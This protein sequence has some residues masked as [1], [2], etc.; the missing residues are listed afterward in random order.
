MDSQA[1]NGGGLRFRAITYNPYN[2]GSPCVDIWGNN[3]QQPMPTAGQTI[4]YVNDIFLW[5]SLSPSM[6]FQAGTGAGLVQPILYTLPPTTN[7]G[8]CGKPL[9][10]NGLVGLN[11]NAYFF[12]RAGFGTD[13]PYYNSIQSFQ[14]G[15]VAN[16]YTAGVYY[17]A[18]TT[19]CTTMS[20]STCTGT[21][22]LGAGA[23]LGGHVDTGHS[24]G[25]PQGSSILSSS[26]PFSIGEG[27]V[28]GMIYHEDSVGCENHYNGSAWHCFPDISG[29]MVGNY[30]TYWASGVLVT[31]NSAFVYNPS[32][33]VVTLTGGAG[34]GFIAPLFNATAGSTNAEFQGSNFSVLG[35]GHVATN[36]WIDFGQHSAPSGASGHAYLW[37]D[38]DTGYWEVAL[39]TTGYSFAVSEN[40]A[41]SPLFACTN[42]STTACIKQS[43]GTFVV[44]GDGKVFAQ[45]FCSNGTSSTEAC[46][47]YLDSSGTLN[48]G[49][50][51]GS[52]LT[53]TG[54]ATIGGSMAV[55]G[56]ALSVTA[57]GVTASGALVSSGSVQAGSG[58]TP[59]IL[60]ASGYIKVN[61]YN[62]ITTTC[63]TYPT[64]VGGIVTSC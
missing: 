15:M 13:L 62:G 27:L 61:G 51:L 19:V 7:T 34:Q 58:G 47:Y 64:V 57:G 10:V 4:D 17:P 30:I 28:A 45:L 60:T 2:S 12:A 24:N 55:N 63:T 35:D 6:P 21:T 56:G 46:T 44:N 48:A 1:V 31:G 18:G 16:S 33:K 41:V 25:T 40:G 52:S 9:A 36:G 20:G 8:P 32:T 50:I 23:Y 11:T 37:Y 53:T 54:G 22:T 38:S 49:I 5:A 26:N 43:S 42:I 14:G 39:G 59:I 29:T 3:V